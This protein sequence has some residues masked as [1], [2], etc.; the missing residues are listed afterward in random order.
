MKFLANYERRFLTGISK[1]MGGVASY[2]WSVSSWA[3]YRIKDAL[4]NETHPS[5][6]AAIDA[7]IGVYKDQ[8]F[9]A[10]P[11]DPRAIDPAQAR[12][13]RERLEDKYY[14]QWR[15][16]RADAQLIDAL[17][18][19]CAQSNGDRYTLCVETIFLDD[20]GHSPPLR[21]RPWGSCDEFKRYY[22]V[23]ACSVTVRPFITSYD[24]A[25]RLLGSLLPGWG[26]SLR[27]A[28]GRSAVRLERGSETGPWKEGYPALALVTAILDRLEKFPEEAPD[29]RSI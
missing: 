13:I 7:M 18:A 25:V 28:A 26:Y 20:K 11:P 2:A 4:R 12:S 16:T 22:Y 5:D 27:Y 29:W 24:D 10:M 8:R 15:A 3:D 19:G 9:K 21:W 17:Y 23:T 6:Q 14:Y 1:A